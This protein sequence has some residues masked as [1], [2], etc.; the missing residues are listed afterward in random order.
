MSH[1]MS[2]DGRKKG[3]KTGLT[4]ST[5]STRAVQVGGPP[6]FTG[7]RK[8]EALA[9][10][11]RLI[12]EGYHPTGAMVGG[13]VASYPDGWL[14]RRSI[15]ERIQRCTR[16]VQRWITRL[17]EDGV[18]GV[19]RNKKGEIPRGAEVPFDCGWSHRFIVG[20]D[21]VGE[22]LRCAVEQARARAS[23]SKLARIIARSI[24]PTPEQKPSHAAPAAASPP[25]GKPRRWTSDELD[26]ELARRDAT[27]PP[28]KPP[29]D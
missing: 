20:I 19:H 9:T 12:A 28:P 14:F 3:A 7:P 11:E 15:G 24:F 27:A 16:T 1:G 23:Q 6:V 17:K 2:D 5:G 22:Q 25:E 10:F 18:M 26:V 21:L 29:P 8:R 4:G 13:I